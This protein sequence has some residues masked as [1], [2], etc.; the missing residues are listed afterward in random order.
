M[1]LNGVTKQAKLRHSQLTE[2]LKVLSSNYD[3]N[4][5]KMM[6]DMSPYDRRLSDL[7]KQIGQDAQYF[8]NRHAK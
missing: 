3:G 2:K 6:I 8:S 1:Q 5:F 7:E 4:S